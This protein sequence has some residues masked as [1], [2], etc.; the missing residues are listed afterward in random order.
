MDSPTHFQFLLK[1]EMHPPNSLAVTEGLLWE[2][3]VLPNSLNSY[4]LTYKH[5][6]AKSHQHQIANH[7]KFHLF[8]TV[9]C[10]RIKYGQHMLMEEV[11]NPEALSKL[12]SSTKTLMKNSSNENNCQEKQRQQNGERTPQNS[13]VC[14][15]TDHTQPSLSTRKSKTEE[16]KAVRHNQWTSS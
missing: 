12:F 3:R 14:G 2:Q 5:P 1:Q 11:T 13:N 9:I 4:M 16:I 15:S 8:N 7:L 10:I 6:A